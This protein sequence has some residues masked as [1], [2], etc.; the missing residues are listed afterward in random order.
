MWLFLCSH[1]TGVAAALDE[2]V[3]HGLPTG[4]GFAAQ[5]LG[6]ALDSHHESGAGAFDGLDDAVVRPGNGADT[7]A[8]RADGLVVKRIDSDGVGLE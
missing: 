3:E 4:V 5:G 2:A 8:D 1:A 7:S 6:M